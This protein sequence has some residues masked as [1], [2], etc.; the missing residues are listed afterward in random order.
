MHE[1]PDNSTAP[2]KFHLQVIAEFLVAEGE[3]RDHAVLLS[4][5]IMEALF[6]AGWEIIS[7]QT[8]DFMIK[9]GVTNKEALTNL[10][11]QQ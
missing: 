6:E 8:V 5:K 9:S 7:T 3:N 10:G 2:T 11:V 1:M 4:R